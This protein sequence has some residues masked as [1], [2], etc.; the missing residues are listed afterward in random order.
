[1][2]LSSITQYIPYAG[3]INGGTPKMIVYNRKSHFNS[4]SH[5]GFP[6][7]TIHFWAFPSWFP[8][9]FPSPPVPS[10]FQKNGAGALHR[11]LLAGRPRRRKWRLGNP[12]PRHGRAWPAG[13]FNERMTG[14][15]LNNMYLYTYM[16]VSWNWGTLIA[17][18]FLSWKIRI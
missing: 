15:W 6:L 12:P 3:Y 16:V 13:L 2:P 9:W 4:W 11:K 1:M 18:W 14:W 17:G 5:G 7:Q 10:T 8:S